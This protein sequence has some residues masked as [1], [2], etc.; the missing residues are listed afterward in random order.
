MNK[1]KS[2]SGYQLV[3]SVGWRDVGKGAIVVLVLKFCMHGSPGLNMGNEL[4]SK[5]RATSLEDWA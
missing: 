2:T 5:E 3:E 4:D 1:R